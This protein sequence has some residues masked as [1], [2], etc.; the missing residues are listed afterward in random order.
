MF[1][2]LC[3][4]KSQDSVYKPQLLK[5]KESRSGSNRG[6]SAYQHSS[7]PLGHTGSHRKRR[8]GLRIFY[9]PDF[10]GHRCRRC[11]RAAVVPPM[12]IRSC[13]ESIEKIRRP[14]SFA[15]DLG[16][17][18]F[19]SP[20]ISLQNLWFMDTVLRLGPHN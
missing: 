6:P 9:V 17:F 8:I 4:A 16:S 18:R 13:Y 10:C 11:F 19:G 1:H 7:L 14:D 5:T 20:F 2:S 12:C 15:T 3:G